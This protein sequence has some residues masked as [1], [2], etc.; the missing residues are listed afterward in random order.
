MN[1]SNGCLVSLINDTASS[2]SSIDETIKIANDIHKQLAEL[3]VKSFEQIKD[4]Y[5]PRNFC[6]ES[7]KKHL[8]DSHQI[9][10]KPG[11]WKRVAAIL[12][13]PWVWWGNLN[14]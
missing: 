3:P 1:S 4:F 10:K 8:T 5:E 14:G 13:A 9:T 11:Y 6:E 7:Y 2:T 12:I